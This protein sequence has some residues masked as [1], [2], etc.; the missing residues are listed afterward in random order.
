MAIG[1]PTDM[2]AFARK[3]IEETEAILT[4]LAI[5]MRDT[6]HGL[7]GEN[8]DDYYSNGNQYYGPRLFHVAFGQQYE[9]SECGA[10]KRYNVLPNRSIAY[11]NYHIRI[12][13]RHCG[14]RD[15][16]VHEAT[17]F[18]QHMTSGEEDAYIK[19]NGVNYSAYL[20]QR[21]ERE[22][23]SAQLFHIAIES[24]ARITAKNLNPEFIAEEIQAKARDGHSIL[25]LLIRCKQAEVI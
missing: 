18:L 10:L 14:R 11:D 12:S 25:P 22:A 16:L 24:P 1:T 2:D 4:R 5:P 7:L 3:L 8:F 13:E 9:Q 15:V 17:H 23:H 19:F 6:W 20:E 21:C